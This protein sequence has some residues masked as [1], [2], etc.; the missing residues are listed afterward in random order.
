MHCIGVLATQC[1]ENVLSDRLLFHCEIRN[2][3]V[4][5]DGLRFEAIADQNR[6]ASY[7]SINTLLTI[8]RFVPHRCFYIRNWSNMHVRT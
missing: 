3:G 8:Q 4:N 1:I 6:I 2:S 5:L 7:T